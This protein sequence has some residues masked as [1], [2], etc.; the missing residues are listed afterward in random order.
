[1]NTFALLCVASFLLFFPQDSS[2]S[3]GFKK[4]SKLSL[5]IELSVLMIECR[6]STQ[7]VHIQ[8][9]PGNI[10]WFDCCVNKET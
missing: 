10:I 1:M 2:K 8:F 7:M 5:D 9:R 6:L 4:A 3:K